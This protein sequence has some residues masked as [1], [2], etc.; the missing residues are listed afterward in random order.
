MFSPFAKPKIAEKLVA[1]FLVFLFLY[2]L[3]NFLTVHGNLFGSIDT[4]AHLIT[5]HPKH[6]HSDIVTHHQGLSD[7]A[8]QNQHSFLLT[9]SF[10]DNSLQKRNGCGPGTEYGWSL[11]PSIDQPRQKESSTVAAKNDKRRGV[12][13]A[14]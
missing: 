11:H 13:R 7:P 3:V 4:N 6:G 2:A 14:F 12:S 1:W 10:R 8:S 5:F 9:D